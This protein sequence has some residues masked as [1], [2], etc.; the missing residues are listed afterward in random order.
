MIQYLIVVNGQIK[1]AFFTNET[2]ELAEAYLN[3]KIYYNDVE[4]F[5]IGYEPETYS[6]YTKRIRFTKGK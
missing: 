6:F 5:E 1:A 3:Y 2:E 4:A